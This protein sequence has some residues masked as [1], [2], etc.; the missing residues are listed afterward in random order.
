MGTSTALVGPTGAGKTTF[1]FQFLA[2]A[3]SEGEKAIF[4]LLEESPAEIRTMGQSIGYDVA[5]L[6]KA[7]LHFITWIPESKSPD[8]FIAELTSQIEAIRPTFVFI[9]SL[10]AFEHFYKQEAYLIT[11]R[12]S[13]L[14]IY[15][16]ITSIFSIL[17]PQ[18]MG[19]NITTLG[20]SSIFHNI[21]LMRYVEAEGQLKRSM[22]IL[23]ARASPHDPS[24]FE[25]SI[26]STGG[27]KIQAAMTEYEG[28]LSGTARRRYDQYVTKERKIDARQKEQKIKRMLKFETHQKELAKKQKRNDVKR[29][30][31]RNLTH[32]R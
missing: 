15:N 28:I 17:A 26:R 14:F 16:N 12:L 23:K 29:K 3:V 1:G 11:K 4:C 5:S 21:I 24:I 9:D 25:F 18:Q 27:I 2:N 30:R 8:A 7:G 19:L 13:N 22:L 20:L 32:N 31:K 10:T 6:E